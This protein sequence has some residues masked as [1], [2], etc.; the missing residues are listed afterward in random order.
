MP[1]TTVLEA[2]VASQEECSTPHCVCSS[3]SVSTNECNHLALCWF[4]WSSTRL[5]RELPLVSPLRSTS[6]CCLRLAPWPLV[7]SVAGSAVLL[8]AMQSLFLPQFLSNSPSGG[9]GP[10]LPVSVRLL[11]APRVSRG[12]SRVFAGSSAFLAFMQVSGSSLRFTA[13]FPRSV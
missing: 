12:F 5:L 9:K 7:T 3:R 13:P 6:S 11:Q 1:L 2:G 10:F 8:H 4:V